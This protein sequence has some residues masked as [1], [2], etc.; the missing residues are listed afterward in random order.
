MNDRK[1]SYLE[2]RKAIPCPAGNPMRDK[3]VLVQDGN[4]LSLKKV[5]EI[6]TVE[7]IQSHL[8]QVSLARM[9]ERFKRGDTTALTRRSGF[10]GDVSGFSDNPAEVINQTR[11]VVAAA[12][13]A[14]S[15]VAPDA[16]PATPDAAPA[17]TTTE[18]EVNPNA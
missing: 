11:K 10:Y 2:K 4:N 3:C 8:D 9:I 12:A 5:G 1:Y 15:D 18:S 6:D 16:A 14:K 17:A 7:Q 13:A